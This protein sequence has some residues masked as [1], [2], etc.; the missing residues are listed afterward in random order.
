M[1]I[2]ICIRG[3]VRRHRIA[4]WNVADLLCGVFGQCHV[5]AN[6]MYIYNNMYSYIRIHAYTYIYI[7]K[8]VY[9]YV[10]IDV[11]MYSCICI[12]ICILIFTYLFIYVLTYSIHLYTRARGPLGSKP[13]GRT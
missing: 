10:C 2:C 13:L 5:G 12:C 11:C 3:T 9:M 6:N 1:C 8:Y 7:C 4:G